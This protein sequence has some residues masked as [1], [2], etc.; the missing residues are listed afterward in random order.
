M[1]KKKNCAN[2]LGQ[3]AVAGLLT[4]ASTL[5][6]AQSFTLLN[7]QLQ[8]SGGS[9]TTFSSQS[10]TISAAGVVGTIIDVPSTNGGGHP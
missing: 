10:P 1:I 5:A 7:N 8:I 2:L 4:I 9:G 3:I 6:S